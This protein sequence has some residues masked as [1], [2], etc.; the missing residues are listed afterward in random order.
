LQIQ[1]DEDQAPIRKRV[2]QQYRA[3]ADTRARPDAEEADIA[4][5]ASRGAPP[6]LASRR[7]HLIAGV[8]LLSP[9]LLG[10]RAEAATPICVGLA[11]FNGRAL[12]VPAPRK[13]SKDRVDRQHDAAS[14]DIRV[15]EHG[16]ARLRPPV[17]GRNQT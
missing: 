14:D 12:L 10:G 1:I 15:V 9:L 6:F 7:S 8:S 11:A 5:S 2:F 17:R 3:E 4:R 16:V 13:R